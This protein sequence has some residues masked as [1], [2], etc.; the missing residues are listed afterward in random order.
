MTNRK[1]LRTV[2]ITLFF[3]L[4]LFLISYHC[5]NYLFV[6]SLFEKPNTALMTKEESVI[7]SK[8]KSL[9]RKKK[10]EEVNKIIKITG[11]DIETDFGLDKIHYRIG[12][13]VNVMMSIYNKSKNNLVIFPVGVDFL[14]ESHSFETD[15][16]R[17]MA[18]DCNMI[19]SSYLK[20]LK[21]N[22][23][24]CKDF[25]IQA[26][27]VGKNQINISLGVPEIRLI[28]KNKISISTK[29]I[30]NYR[31]VYDVE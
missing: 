7:F 25:S 22:D 1:L 5:S 14:S 11:K 16:M 24:Y 28:E 4:L 9:L 17:D 8:I 26:S 23:S 10:I 15:N 19:N 31:I 21:P 3:A 6:E 12:D 13:K 29:P 18:L 20:L 2:L 27:T 30:K